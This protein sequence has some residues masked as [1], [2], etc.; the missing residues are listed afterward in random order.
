[1]KKP[2]Y[3]FIDTETTGLDKQVHSIHQIAAILIDGESYKEID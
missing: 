1:M 3:C 2:N